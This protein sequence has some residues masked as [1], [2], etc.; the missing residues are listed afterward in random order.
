[1]RKKHHIFCLLVGMITLAF[2]A[3]LAEAQDA[4]RIGVVHNFTDLSGRSIKEGA[5]LAQEHMNKDGGIFVRERGKKVPVELFFANDGGKAQ[6]SSS[7]VEKLCNSDKVDF[8]AGANG[9]E[10]TLAQQEMAMDYKKIFLSSGAAGIQ[11]WKN[12][13]KNYSRYKYYFKYEP[14]D[15]LQ[16]GEGMVEIG[17]GTAKAIAKQ[18]NIPIK[19]V[20]AAFLAEHAEWAEPVVKMAQETFKKEGIDIVYV[21]RPSRDATDLTTEVVEASRKGAKMIWACFSYEAGYAMVRQIY[22]LKLPLIATGYNSVA[23]DVAGYWKATAG[24]GI[25]SVSWTFVPPRI[26][27][28]PK[29]IPFY[30]AH[31]ARW[32]HPPLTYRGNN[33]YNNMFILKEAIEKAGTLNADKLVPI[34]EDLQYVGIMGTN[35]VDPKTHNSISG[36]GYLPN[37]GIQWIEGGKQEVIYPDYLKS[38]DITLPPALLKMKK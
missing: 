20:K 12:V 23:Q 34:L 33:Q 5:V 17:V 35:K 3:P 24:K 38:S 4:V 37:I 14:L 9:T 18:L 25:Y 26:P 13:E 28:T 19:E 10:L 29:T 31:V 22:D 36:K 2:L 16:L 32:S 15:S 6:T 8:L 7:A 1:M 30:D 21:A 11:L 27:L